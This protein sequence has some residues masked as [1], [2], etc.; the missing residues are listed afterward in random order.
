MELQ[1]DRFIVRWVGH[2]ACTGVVGHAGT[3]LVGKREGR[4]YRV[5]ECGTS[6]RWGISSL[7]EQLLESK[8]WL[9]CQCQS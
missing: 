7:T 5:L 6:R 9:F 3:I 8:E 1:S 4:R 2:V